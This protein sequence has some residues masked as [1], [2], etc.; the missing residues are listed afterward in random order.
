M[1]EPAFLLPL[2]VVDKPEEPD[3][4]RIEREYRTTNRSVRELGRENG[5]SHTA[6]N[7][8][9]ASEGWSRP[10][11]NE[12]SSPVSR[13]AFEPAET[14]IAGTMLAKAETTYTAQERLE[15]ARQELSAALEEQRETSPN[16]ESDGPRVV[17][18]KQAIQAAFW[19]AVEI[20]KPANERPLATAANLPPADG[21]DWRG[22][23]DVLAHRQLAIAVY[24]NER[25]EVVI[26][27]EAD[28][29]DD[30]DTYIVVARE[31]VPAL[32]R[33]LNELTAR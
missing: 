33:R 22:D 5:V 17:A 7:K 28:W 16:A 23:P 8:R 26:R 32:I 10:V 27:Q 9:A 24:E 21:F 6:I 29:N 20:E 18:A 1:R 4:A 31:H 14:S 11:S 2:P 13:R 25:G 19:E 3:W 15:L 12:V 30:E